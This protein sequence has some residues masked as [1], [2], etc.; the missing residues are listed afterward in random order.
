MNGWE[1]EEAAKNAENVLRLMESGTN[2]SPMLES[3][4]RTQTSHFFRDYLNG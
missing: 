3:F 2:H 4:G 1:E